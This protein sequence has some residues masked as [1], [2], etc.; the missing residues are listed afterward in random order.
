MDARFTSISFDASELAEKRGQFLLGVEI[1]WS[2]VLHSV[3]KVTV[4]VK[5]VGLVCSE[6]S[7]RGSVFLGGKSG[8]HMAGGRTNK[9]SQR[10]VRQY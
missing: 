9:K 4:P 3:S 2:L 6:A 7:G 10:E 8:G 5:S 1:V